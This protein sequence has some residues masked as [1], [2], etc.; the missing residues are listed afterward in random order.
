MGPIFRRAGAFFIRRSFAGD[1]LYPIVVDAYIRRLIREGYPVEMFL[2]GGRSRTGKLLAPKFGLL[3]MIVSA[4]LAEPQR[5][6]CFVPVSI[7]Y[8]RV[9]DSY[10]LELGGGEKAKEDAAGL[11]GSA[12]I[13]RSRYGR[14]N[15]Q[16][17]QVLTL[18]HIRAD[19]ALPP[20]TLSPAKQ[21]AVVTRLGNRVMDEI[22]RVTSVTP[23]ALTALALLS[24]HR[25]GQPHE[26]LLVRCERLLATCAARRR[27]APACHERRE[28]R[29]DAIRE[30]AQMFADGGV[31]R[32][33]LSRGGWIHQAQQAA[34]GR[35]ADLHRARRQAAEAGRLEEH[36]HPFLRRAGTRG[37]RPLLPPAPIARDGR[38]PS[39]HRGRGA[40]TRAGAVAPVQV[41]V[42]LS[43]RRQLRHHL[44]G[45]GRGMVQDG[46]LSRRDQQPGP[47]GP[48]GWTGHQWLMTMRAAAELRRILSR[49]GAGLAGL[50]K[51]PLDAKDLLKQ[52]LVDGRLMYLSGEVERA[53]AISKPL[54]QNAFAAFADLGYVSQS[55]GRCSYRTRPLRL[56]RI[57][58]RQQCRR[59]QCLGQQ[60]PREHSGQR[61]AA[62]GPK[63]RR[64]RQHAALSRGMHR[65]VPGP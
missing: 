52:T 8:E 16:F 45:H 38:D 35:G 56:A 39:P 40:G 41:R 17:G 11:L 19:L 62:D 12:N 57:V 53:E 32:G 2:E 5:P 20:G 59:A 46:D 6:V 3:K 4:A 25:R 51:G 54:I 15:L 7:G 44:R 33:G 18:D 36:H 64:H 23:G 31:A 30:A 29:S 37:A 63:E 43:R 34:R 13:L 26:K 24:Y 47:A 1:A 10:E 42:S 48:R 61:A 21:R 50:E 22:N 9:V 65:E 60:R 27:T 28:L 14:M 58:P 49:R 55:A